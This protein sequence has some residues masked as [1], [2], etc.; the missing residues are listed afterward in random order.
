MTD[1][2]ELSEADNNQ[3]Y[4]EYSSLLNSKNELQAQLDNLYQR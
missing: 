2:Y 4:E 3:L 1:D